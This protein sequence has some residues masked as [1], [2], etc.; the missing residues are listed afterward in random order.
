[1]EHSS[2][3]G[4]PLSAILENFSYEKRTG[5]F[6]VIIRDKNKNAFFYMEDGMIWNA[7]YGSLRGTRAL[8]SLLN[9][10]EFQ[11][12]ALPTPKRKIRREIQESITSLLMNWYVQFDQN[13]EKTFPNHESGA[14]PLSIASMETDGCG[15][16]AVQEQA[17]APEMLG[18]DFSEE[19]PAAT[20]G[21]SGEASLSLKEDD[22]GKP[23]PLAPI[24]DAE[25]EELDKI[26][27]KMSAVEG[28]IACAV[29]SPEGEVLASVNNAGVKLQEIGAL[30][31]DILLKSQHAAEMMGVGR[32]QCVHM[33][34]PKGH[35]LAR[36]LNEATDFTVTATGRAHFHVVMMIAKEGNIAL[37]KMRLNNAMGEIAPLLR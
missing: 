4:M 34:A 32:A 9:E 35:A 33:E 12:R 13:S 19:P 10:Q 30:A 8:Y 24:G 20:D 6:V 29:V 21:S 27:K 11:I 31:N 17:V 7:V 25:M 16:S 36:C 3:K 5:L 26:L 18:V 23:S 37:A 15:A 14:A 2:L 22:L 1:M 28:F